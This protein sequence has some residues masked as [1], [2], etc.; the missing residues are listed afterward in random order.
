MLAEKIRESYRLFTKKK[1]TENV[2]SLLKGTTWKRKTEE[3]NI[4]QYAHLYASS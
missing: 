1:K 4:K 2:I 3:N